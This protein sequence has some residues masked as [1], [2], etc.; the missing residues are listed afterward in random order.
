MKQIKKKELN[1]DEILNNILNSIKETIEL[2]KCHEFDVLHKEYESRL[3][4]NGSVQ[5]FEDKYKK[6]FLG[7]IVGVHSNGMLKVQ[8]EENSI[9]LY[10]HKQIKFL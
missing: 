4:K 5:M 10:D 1:R 8:N 7:K 9:K 6:Q 2:L 3:F